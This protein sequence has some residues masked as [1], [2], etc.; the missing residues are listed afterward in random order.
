[1]CP[2]GNNELHLHCWP[3]FQCMETDLSACF[4]EGCAKELLPRHINQL[5]WPWPSMHYYV[6]LRSPWIMIIKAIKAWFGVL[7]KLPCIRRSY[8]GVSPGLD[9]TTI[10]AAKGHF[11]SVSW[12]LCFDYFI[13]FQDHKLMWETRAPVQIK[14]HLSGYLLFNELSYGSI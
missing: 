12:L 11:G 2:D 8:I 14:V 13:C 10:I 7:I 4:L 1:M 3:R 9:Y 5:T 6:N